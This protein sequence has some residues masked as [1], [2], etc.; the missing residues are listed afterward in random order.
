[1]LPELIRYFKGFVDFC[2][3]GKAPERFLNLCAQRGVRV[4]NARPEKDGLH[5][6]MFARD[7]RFIRKTARRA[8]VR[9]RV[10]K[11]RGLP[12]AAVRYRGRIG[13]PAGALAGAVLLIVLS[14]YVWTMDV[15]GEKT[16]SEQRL[17]ALLAESGVYPGARR[18]GVDAAQAKRDVLL[19]AEE[20]GWMSVNIVGCHAGVEIKEKVKKP[21]TD[22]DPSPANIKASA[23]G[24]ITDII[25]ERGFAQVKRNSGAAQGDLLI[26][27]VST[28]KNG[29]VSYTRAK[30]E[31]WADVTSK[32]EIYI[33]DSI[34]YYSLTENKADRFRLRFL[35]LDFPCSFSFRSFKTA[36]YTKSE[37]S[38]VVNQTVLPLGIETETARELS[39]SQETVSR[40]T[41]QKQLCRAA[42]L[43]ELFE[44]G[45]SKRVKKSL[46]VKQT[47]G[48]FLCRADYVFN[49]NI[50][51][52]VDFSVEE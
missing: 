20:I 42:L 50:A 18:S 6:R 8:G 16:V 30:G 35:R 36:A 3:F 37:Q 11:R 25:A 1:M 21:P 27:G 49:E 15:T 22:N 28:D 45:E 51:Q 52:T 29:N 33:P 48:G 32:R 41:A 2:A 5:G 40:D 9:T 23:D 39:S 38:L 31:V 12:F 26:S 34:N 7:Y 47:D 43:Y 46:T 13:L 4:W 17:R 44:K 19:S 10:L 24:V 14:G